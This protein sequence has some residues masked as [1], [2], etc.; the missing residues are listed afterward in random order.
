[1]HILK[2][3][4]YHASVVEVKVPT[5]LEPGKEGERFAI[6]EPADASQY[7]GL[8]DDREIKPTKIGGTWFPKPYK[9]SEARPDQEDVVLHFHGGAYVIG[10]GRQEDAGFCASTL[11]KSAR[12]DRVFSLQYRLS[13]NPGGRF[14]AA[15]QDAL[16]SYLYLIRTLGIP[17][18]RITISGDSAGGNL[19]LA[20][21]RY[22]EEYGSDLS[23]PKPVACFLWS[24]WVNISAAKDSRNMAASPNYTTDY[25]NAGF[26][27]WGARCYTDGIGVK[28]DNPYISPL[29]NPFKTDTIILVQTG[30]AEVLY[31]DNIVI[32][33]EFRNVPGNSTKLID[34]DAAPHDIALVGHRVGFVDELR[35]AM[36]TAGEFL[37][38][39]KKF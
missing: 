9:R 23:I 11:I 34:V 5:P 36:K 7:Q 21:L 22:L 18:H 3:F 8:M 12:V 2:A 24:P 27:M 1:M 25:L 20:L 32:E 6:I 37:R 39:E 30:R 19:A 28:D 31:H 16:T 35:D 4:L 17:S 38:N 29:G 33:E 10:D 14:P 13:S 26:G 15:L